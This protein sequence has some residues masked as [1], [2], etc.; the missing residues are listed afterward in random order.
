MTSLRLEH[1]VLKILDTFPQSSKIKKYVI[2]KVCH[3]PLHFTESPNVNTFH[4]QQVD[5]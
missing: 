3:E 2:L 5:T 4:S 1:F